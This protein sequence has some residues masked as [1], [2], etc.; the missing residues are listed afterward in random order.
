MKS[1]RLLTL[2]LLSTLLLAPEAPAAGAAQLQADSQTALQSLYAANPKARAL[3]DKAYAILVFPTV[4]KAGFLMAGM[5]RGD[6]VL[7]EKGTVAGYYNT[8]SVNGG[9]QIGAQTFSYAL[10]FMTKDDLRNLNN[11]AGFNLGAAPS[12]TV[13]DAGVAATSSLY[14]LHGIKA[15][16]FGQKGLMAGVGL[17]GTKI[18]QYTPS[19]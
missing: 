13:A 6:G 3:G 14:S 1:L 7:L 17:S 11:S 4:I 10:F 19:N 12:L 9:P 16:I 18:S 2:T 15:F 5:Q 8:T